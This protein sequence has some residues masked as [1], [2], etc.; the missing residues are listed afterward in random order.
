MSCTK[1]IGHSN[2][3]SYSE[4]INTDEFL[5]K[6]SERMEQ[7][8]EFIND[9][10]NGVIPKTKE[11]ESKLLEIFSV[12]SLEYILLNNT[13]KSKAS[14][15]QLYKTKLSAQFYIEGELATDPVECM[16]IRDAMVEE[17]GKYGSYLGS[18]C[19]AAVGIAYM[20]RC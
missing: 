15:M 13:V 17:C 10:I 7:H 11:S 8:K 3:I 2:E 4:R 18:I 1:D 6:I 16:K 20:L 5:L 19:K 9:Y 14:E 12:N